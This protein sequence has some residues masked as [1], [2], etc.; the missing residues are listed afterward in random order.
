MVLPVQKPTKSYW[1]EAAGST[2]RN[3]QSTPQLPQETDVIIVGSGYAGTTS[4]YWIHKHTERDGT[5]PQMLVLEAREICGGATGRNGGQ[6]R[7]HAYSRYTSWSS[8]FG[9][10]GALALIKHEMAHLA[11]FKDLLTE[12]GLAEEVCLQFGDTFDAPMTEAEWK[13]LKGEYDAFVK[14]HG[15]DGEVIRDCRLIEDVEEAEAFT[16]IKGCFGAVVHPAG[17]VWPYKFVHA[18]WRILLATGKVNLH[19][20]TPALTVSDKD[21]DGWIT[22]NTPRGNVRTRAVVHA[23]NAWAS[24]LLPEYS[25]IIL[26]SVSTVGA[27]KAPAG[28]LKPTGAQHFGGDIYNYHLQ[29]P[30]P[31]NA[32]I[33]GGAKSVLAHY[34]HDWLKR[35][36]DD[37]HLPGVPE[38]LASWPTHEVVGW[39]EPAAELALPAHEGGVWTGVVAPTADGFPFV[40]AAPAREGH[41]LVAGFGG[42]GMPRILLATAQLTPAVLDCLG[43]K[44]SAPALVRAYPPLPKAFVAT[45]K[46]VEMLRDFDVKAE[47][48]EDVKEMQLSA[49]KAC[50]TE[51]RCLAWKTQDEAATAAASQQLAY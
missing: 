39:P 8:R 20:N 25:N 1:I 9:A 51:A 33:L 37:H 2:L 27:I 42:H 23:T 5:T 28:F 22:V 6:L 41:F 32:I 50:C 21:A 38:Y 14:D 44:W 45:E 49:Q 40:G 17:Q 36:D 48:E 10:D 34:P 47:Y 12:E 3:F 13:R 31:H 15:K 26:P 29:L 30:P 43:V 4:A 24:H 19:A 16:Q 46:R 18:I 35:G 11:A 7:P